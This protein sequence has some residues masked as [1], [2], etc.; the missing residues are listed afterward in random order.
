MSS[1]GYSFIRPRCIRTQDITGRP[2]KDGSD[3]E[4]SGNLRRA[5]PSTPARATLEAII[6]QQTD[7]DAAKLAPW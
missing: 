1:A 3:G 6:A 2:T 5:R 7:K 4:L